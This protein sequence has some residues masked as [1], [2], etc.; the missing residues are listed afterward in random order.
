MLKLVFT[1]YGFIFSE[2]YLLN[3]I[4]N[5][6]LFLQLYNVVWT[7]FHNVM[8][9]IITAKA[10]YARVE[11]TPP[12]VKDDVLGLLSNSFISFILFAT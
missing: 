7:H 10:Y 8:S 12:M 4:A 3:L 6:I 9:Y 5:A 11:S 1:K 2:K